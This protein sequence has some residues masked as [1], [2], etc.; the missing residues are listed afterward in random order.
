MLI[1][2]LFLLGSCYNDTIDTSTNTDSEIIDNVPIGYD[3]YILNTSS[4]KIHKAT[5][6]TAKLISTKNK[7]YYSDNISK[8]FEQGYTYCGNCYKTQ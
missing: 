8:L 6:G 5:C 3:T 1:S 2:Q 7:K 4:K